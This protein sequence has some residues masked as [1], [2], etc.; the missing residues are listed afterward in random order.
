MDKHIW[1][2]KSALIDMLFDTNKSLVEIAEYF[3][4]SRTE[5][6]KRIKAY[7]LD[8]VRRSSRKMSRGQSSLMY[9]IK[10]LIPGS[11]IVNEFHI[12]EKLRL[13][14]YLP[15]YKLAIEYHGRQHYVHIPAFHET[16]DDF[17]RAQE[18]DERKSQLCAENGITLVSFR[19]TDDLSE[20]AVYDRIL[21]AIRNS[22]VSEAVKPKYKPNLSPKNS[23]QFEHAKIKRKEFE[24]DIRKKIKNERKKQREQDRTSRT[25]EE[26]DLD[27]DNND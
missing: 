7:G 8:W 16:Y 26:D 15:S 23:P 24:R 1:D 25:E 27:Q 22:Q 20:D 9:V 2:E 18:R 19:Y 4:C 17:I 10:K 13:D 12:G 14:I 11:E 5:L 21:N 3:E 6:S